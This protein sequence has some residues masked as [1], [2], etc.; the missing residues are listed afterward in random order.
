MSNKICTYQDMADLGITISGIS[1]MNKCPTKAEILAIGDY[2][3][4]T[5]NY[6]SNQL[7]KYDDITAIPSGSILSIYPV[8]FT[9]DGSFVLYNGS[10]TNPT[11]LGG[12]HSSTSTINRYNKHSLPGSN[13]VTY[14]ISDFSGIGFIG[15]ISTLTSTISKPCIGDI[16]ATLMVHTSDPYYGVYDEIYAR[17]YDV[18]R[19]AFEAGITVWL[20]RSQ[21]ALTGDIDLQIEVISEP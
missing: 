20:Y 21:S 14:D 4:N 18:D 11:Y 13:G 12:V 2:M 8:N 6:A 19:G 3:L 5:A 9:Y 15:T 1:N 7:V 10:I 17:L 16:G